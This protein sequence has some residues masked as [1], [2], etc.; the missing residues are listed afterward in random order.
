MRGWNAGCGYLGT[1]SCSFKRVPQERETRP[2]MYSTAGVYDSA[3]HII[4]LAKELR[5]ILNYQRA[6]A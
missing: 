4:I 6:I 3:G 5:I 2:L 1:L